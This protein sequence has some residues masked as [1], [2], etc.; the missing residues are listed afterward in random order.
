MGR[1]LREIRKC[2]LPEQ[3]HLIQTL[4]M[5]QQRPSNRIH[6]YFSRMCLSSG[7][8]LGTSLRPIHDNQTEKQHLHTRLTKVNHVRSIHVPQTSRN[9]SHDLLTLHVSR[10]FHGDFSVLIET[11]PIETRPKI[12][13]PS[14]QRSRWPLIVWLSSELFDLALR[15]LWNIWGKLEK[16]RR[17][18]EDFEGNSEKIRKTPKTP[19]GV[20][21]FP[22]YLTC[23]TEKKKLVDMCHV[24]HLP[25]RSAVRPSIGVKTPSFSYTENRWNV[26]KHRYHLH[27]GTSIFDQ[28]PISTNFGVQKPLSFHWCWWESPCF[29]MTNIIPKLPKAIIPEFFLQRLLVCFRPS[30]GTGGHRQ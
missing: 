8:Q 26:E 17:T 4:P 19:H 27:V 23:Q 14:L 18:S 22:T 6:L 16:N 29:L 20:D 21:V 13:R 9:Q 10:G 30:W 24:Y 25:L 3:T 11:F 12:P 28:S 5:Q 2:D 15:R 7:E 1:L